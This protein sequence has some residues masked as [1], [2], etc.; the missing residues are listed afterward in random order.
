MSTPLLQDRPSL[1]TFQAKFAEE[2]YT[3]TYMTTLTE[4][5]NKL[6][7]Q[8]KSWLK[9]GDESAGTVAVQFDEDPTDAITLELL[10]PITDLVFKELPEAHDQQFYLGQ[11]YGMLMN[12]LHQSVIP[13]LIQE[14]RASKQQKKSPLIIPGGGGMFGGGTA[15]A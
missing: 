10:K 12:Q 2:S 14:A 6:K 11:L 4:V 1:K 3:E 9:V 13:T 8:V 15:Q 5:M 7:D